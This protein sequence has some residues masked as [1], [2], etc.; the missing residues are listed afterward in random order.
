MTLHFS[1]SIAGFYERVRKLVNE[2]MFVE[3]GL[4][5]CPKVVARN[6]HKAQSTKVK[7][8]SSYHGSTFSA[9]MSARGNPAPEREHRRLP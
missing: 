6:K 5:G 7:L 8:Q 9:I 2:V 1:L 4:L 3:L